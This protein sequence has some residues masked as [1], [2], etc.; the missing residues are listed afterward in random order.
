MVDP[1]IK[2]V[3]LTVIVK[4]GPP[5]LTAAGDI[6]KTDGK[7][8]SGLVLVPEGLLLHPVNINEATKTLSNRNNFIAVIFLLKGETNCF[9]ILIAFFYG[10]L[11]YW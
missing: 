9:G 7:G 8:L 10:L 5:A 11:T 1:L 6:D 3:P 4:A 2:F